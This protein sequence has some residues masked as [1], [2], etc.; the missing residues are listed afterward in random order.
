MLQYC[1]PLVYFGILKVF[2][3][4]LKAIPLSVDLWIHYMTHVKQNYAEDDVFVRSQFERA[5]A[6]CGLEFRSDKLWEAYIRWETDGKRLVNVLPIYDKLLMT[7]TQG[8]NN[9]YTR[10]VHSGRLRCAKR[11]T[12]AVVYTVVFFLVA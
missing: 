8:F 2:D 1:F 4:G 10:Y 7:P 3:R 5:L 9:N 12:V 11:A 6:T